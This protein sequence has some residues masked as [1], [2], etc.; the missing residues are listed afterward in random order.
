MRFEILTFLSR[1]TENN[2]VRIALAA[3]LSGVANALT[4]VIVTTAAQDYSQMNFRY[5][6]L[7]LLAVLLY[8][9][10]FRYSLS[11]ATT[12][13]QGIISRTQLRIAG[14]IKNAGLRPFERIGNS[15]VHTTLAENSEIIFEATRLLVNCTSAALMLLV[16]AL[17]LAVISTTAFW[18]ATALILCSALGF[19]YNQKR[20]DQDLAA[21]AAKE[22]D[23]YATLDHILDGFMEV[24][25]NRARGRDILDNH[26]HPLAQGLKEIRIATEAKFLD[27]QMYAQSFWF[28]LIA[29]IVFMLPQI[30]STPNN[31]VM[32]ITMVVLFSLGSVATIVASVP[33]IVKANFAVKR[34]RELEERLDAAADLPQR[35]AARQLAPEKPFSS[36]E[37]RDLH[38][39]Y[40]EPKG[41]N[42]FS[43]G[44]IDLT[45]TAGEI[46]FLVGGNGSGK[47][48]LL[49]NI[50]GLYYPDRG[51]ILFNGMVLSKNDYE[52]YRNRI[53]IVFTDFHLF[54]RL[55]GITHVDEERLNRL[56]T[57][58]RLADKT[59]YSDGL[60]STT[61]LSTGQRKRLAVITA[62]MEEREIMIFDELAADQD[63]EFRTY[64][65]E[66]FL[67]GLK[68]DGK[69]ILCTSHD[70]R[71]FHLADQVVRMEYGRILPTV[72]R[73]AEQ[74]R[75]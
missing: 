39:L 41:H 17:Y 75:Q 29:S 18:I 42:G 32:S 52:E 65:Y 70:D 24:K 61:S 73:P 74:G 37:L 67:P 36:L 54:D 62:L 63:P 49:K 72:Q 60:F 51:Q 53:S 71:Y 48:T 22:S 8:T 19:L 59:E 31:T 6:L 30:S 5:L 38:F 26:L 64:F 13:V 27:N 2:G 46:T 16:A 45:I 9:V 3:F 14:K 4:I 7:F 35:K 57:T 33:I 34:L 68:A 55:Y 23:Y 10:T 66:Q 44:P 15:T 43:I 58:M 28:L 25:M 1:E 40:D 50:A 21:A 11:A 12:E 56:L 47:T 69:T 20:I